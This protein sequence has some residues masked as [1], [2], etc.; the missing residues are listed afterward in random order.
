MIRFTVPGKP[1]GKGRPRFRRAGNFVKTYTPDQ[2]VNYEKRVRESWEQGHFERLQGEI[3]ARMVCY[4]PI[5]K[6]TPKKRRAAMEAG[7]I[8]CS[9]K[10]DADNLAKCVL[11]A[12]NG[13]AYDDDSHITRLEVRK[14]YS[15]D[16]RCEVELTEKE[17]D[18]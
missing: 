9:T 15:T 16:P 14:L 6:S 5:P 13:L 2:T 7:E 4:F 1:E 3:E 17:N 10:P 18:K 8:G 12:L 11:D